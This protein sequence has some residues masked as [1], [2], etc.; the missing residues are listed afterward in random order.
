MADL[1]NDHP[2]TVVVGVSATSKSPAALTW[3]QAQAEHCGGRPRDV[4]IVT[5][6]RSRDKV[7]EIRR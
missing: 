5:G 7:V 4:E 2:Y 3:A 1:E 6:H